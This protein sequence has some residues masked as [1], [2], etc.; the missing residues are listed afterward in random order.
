MTIYIRSL[1]QIGS[2]ILISLPVDWVKKNYLAKGKNV[3]VETNND[4]S[5]SIYNNNQEEE[6]KIEF[7]YQYNKSE[8]GVQNDNGNNKDIIV[9]SVGKDTK[10]IK[11]LLNKIFGAY[12]LGYSII[13]IKSKEPISFDDSETIKKS[14]RKLIGL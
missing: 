7:C 9:S 13:N 14:I 10:D 4:N 12:L 3:S 8:F 2:S 6:I 11:I 5:I 1:Q